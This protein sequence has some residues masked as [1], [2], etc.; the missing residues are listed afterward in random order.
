MLLLG[1]DVGTSSIKVSVVDAQTQDCLASA[2]HPEEESDILAPQ[3][4]WAEQ[5]PEMWWEHAKAAIRKVNATGRYNPVDIGAIGIAYQMHGL[6]VVNKEQQALRNAIIWCDS[7]A[8]EIG[9]QA[10]KTIGEERSLS[11]LL[12]SPGNFTASKLAWVKANEP[13]LYDNIDKIMLPGDY[14]AMKLTG[15]IT[16]SVSALSE[17]VFWDFQE[18]ELSSDVL[19]YYK[20]DKHLIP[21]INPVFSEHGTVTKAVA[22]ELGLKAG[23]PVTYKSGDQPNNALSLNV[24]QPGEV[25]ATAGTSGVIY[26]VSDKLLYDPQSRV[27]TFAHVNY[28][29]SDKRLGMLLC[30]NGTGSLNRWMKN[31]AGPGI[32]YADMNQMAAAIPIGSNGLRVIPFGNGAERMLNNKIVGTHFHHID[33]NLHTKAHMFRAVQEGIA[34][35]FRYGLDIMRESGMNPSII[36][37]GQANLFLSETFTEAFVNATHVPVELYLNDGSIGAALGAGIGVKAF[38]SEKEA[39]TN[40]KRLRTVEPKAIDL[41][42][43]AYQEWKALLEKHLNEI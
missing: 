4:G 17:G 10:F 37:A 41:Y 13:G 14:V 26:G 38:V 27:N 22:D 16:T 8:V 1:I 11:R 18:N 30:I 7:R 15:S 5:A 39:F 23:I 32:S 12:N 3:A 19:G 40:S 9:N 21:V 20:F 2:Q 33:L 34:F 42:E 35:A 28:A 24:L 31:I 29:D 25:A 6:V 36:R 43:P